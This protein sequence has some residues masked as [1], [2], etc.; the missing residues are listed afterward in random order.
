MWD[1]T[2]AFLSVLMEFLA[3]VHHRHP[4]IEARP[5]KVHP[6]ASRSVARRG[7]GGARL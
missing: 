2:D 3:A 4:T 5:E 6:F 7:V 1:A